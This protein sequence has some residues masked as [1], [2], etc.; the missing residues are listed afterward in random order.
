MEIVRHV[1]DPL[2]PG[3]ENWTYVV[4]LVCGIQLA[5]ALYLVQ[6]PDWSSVWVTMIVTSIVATFYAVGMG[7][8]LMAQADNEVIAM[9]GLTQWHAGGY[10]SLWCFLLTLLT[11]LL[12]YA[13]VRTSLKW[14][15]LF[16]LAVAHAKD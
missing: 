14:H 4:L 12:S 1:R 6:L 11:A 15:K 7:M 10:L 3:I 9:L 5:Y 2:S 16:E 8:S 13:M